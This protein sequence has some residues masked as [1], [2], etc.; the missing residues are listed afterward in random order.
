MLKGEPKM[1][2]RLRAHLPA[3]VG[4]PSIVAH[5]LYYGAYK[6]QPAAANL[7]RIE[8]LQLEVVPFDTGDAQHAGEIRAQLVA[9][10]TQ[11][12]PYDVL[13]AGQAMASITDGN[14]ADT[15]GSVIAGENQMGAVIDLRHVF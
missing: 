2:A 13:I 4:M 12:G 7:G 6:S 8:A 11:V 9:A 3:D 15:D 5:E 10:G 1:L 14:R